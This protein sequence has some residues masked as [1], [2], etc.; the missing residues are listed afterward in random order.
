MSSS[1]N[2]QRHPKDRPADNDPT[3]DPRMAKGMAALKAAL[4]ERAFQEPT[5]NAPHASVLF[6]DT[7]GRV[8]VYAGVQST[9]DRQRE[10][11]K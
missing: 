11:H 9:E 2:H 7:T 3:H 6:Y 5:E 4:G 10:L 1:N 8:S